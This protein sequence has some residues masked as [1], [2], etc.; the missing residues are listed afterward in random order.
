MIRQTLAQKSVWPYIVGTGLIAV[1]IL[2][3]FLTVQILP[4]I[5]PPA[6][7][8]RS[9]EA[10]GSGATII[11]PAD[12]KFFDAG[13]MALLMG[14]GNSDVLANVNPADRKFYTNEYTI[15]SGESRSVDPLANV[16]PAD[17]K[18]FTAEYVA[19]D[20]SGAID[21]LAN[22]YPADRKFFNDGYMSGTP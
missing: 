6:E 17:R 5:N 12:K 14:E 1:V 2:L 20:L 21:P 8:G 7:I 13:H 15:G 18:F 19:G 10:S 16:D 4:T 11:H 3:S 22:V 9:V